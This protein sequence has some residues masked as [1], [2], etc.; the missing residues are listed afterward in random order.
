MTISIQEFQESTE[1]PQ[2]RAKKLSYDELK[3]F[4]PE[5]MKEVKR[6]NLKRQDRSHFTTYTKEDVERE[7]RDKIR[8][9]A[10]QNSSLAARRLKGLGADPEFLK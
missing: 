5:A 3:E 6:E 1:S 4:F 9:Q 2:P 8:R 7:F 10:A